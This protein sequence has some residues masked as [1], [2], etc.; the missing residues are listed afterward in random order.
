VSAPL[1]HQMSVGLGMPRQA[2]SS[3]IAGCRDRDV[4]PRRGEP[5]LDLAMVRCPIEVP[6]GIELLEVFEEELG[7]LMSPANALSA[8]P[9][10]RCVE[11]AGRELILFPRERAPGAYDHLLARLRRAGATVNVSRSTMAM[12]QH[13]STLPLRPGAISMASRRAAAPPDI[14]WRPL[15]GRPLTAT[16]AVAWHAATRNARLRA[17]LARMRR[18]LEDG[19]LTS[20]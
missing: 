5:T 1:A 17:M 14:L 19:P 20:D 8:K 13:R 9:V 15:E 10:L 7:V 16:V 11:L 6:G 2:R 4:L 18:E 12:S 3:R